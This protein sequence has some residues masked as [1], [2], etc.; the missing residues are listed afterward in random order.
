MANTGKFN[1]NYKLINIPSK[2]KFNNAYFLLI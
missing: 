2:F 1:K